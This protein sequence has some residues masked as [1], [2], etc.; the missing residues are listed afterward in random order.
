ML[1][2][3]Y[4]YI[5]ALKLYDFRSMKKDIHRLYQ[6]KEMYKVL[7]KRTYKLCTYAYISILLVRCQLKRM[8]ITSLNETFSGFK[9]Y[10]CVC[11][12]IAMYI[13]KIYA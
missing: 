7:Y 2:A 4:M 6:E 9:I 11:V 3:T 13:I 10:F 1:Y 12:D 8:L 5:I